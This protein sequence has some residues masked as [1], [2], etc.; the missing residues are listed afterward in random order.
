MIEREG[1]QEEEETTGEEISQ[2]T[3]TGGDP[4]TPTEGKIE[5]RGAEG[6]I[7]P[8]DPDPKKT[9]PRPIPRK[10]N[11]ATDHTKEE[12]TAGPGNQAG[13]TKEGEKEDTIHKIPKEDPD[14]E[15]RRPDIGPAVEAGTQITQG[16]DPPLL[17]P[18]VE[19]M[20]EEENP[21]LEEDPDP[22]PREPPGETH[23]EVDPARGN[24]KPIK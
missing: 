8:S 21:L 10:G 5:E 15:I 17:D 7:L 12:A 20:P 18:E 6:E 16:I 1:D 19:K 9:G 23:L 4:T 24:Q 22:D 3:E 13:K 11:P 2:E 14:P